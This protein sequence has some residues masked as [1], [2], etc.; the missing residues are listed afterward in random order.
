MDAVLFMKMLA[1]CNIESLWESPLSLYAF[2]GGLCRF[3]FCVF[4]V[5]AACDMCLEAARGGNCHGLHI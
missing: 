5:C 4:A 2:S 1:V 3:A